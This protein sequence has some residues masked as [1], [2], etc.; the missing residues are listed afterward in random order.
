MREDDR[1]KNRVGKVQ[2][3]ILI[4]LLNLYLLKDIYHW[5]KKVYRKARLQVN[6]KKAKKIKEMM[7]IE[8][9]DY[10]VKKTF[11]NWR[12]VAPSGDHMGSPLQQAIEW[13]KPSIVPSWSPSERKGIQP[14][15]R[16]D[17]SKK[18][19]WGVFRRKFV[20][21][22]KL[23]FNAIC[24]SDYDPAI[25]KEVNG[26]IDELLGEFARW[27]PSERPRFRGDSSWSPSERKGKTS[28]SGGLQLHFVLRP[29]TAEDRNSERLFEI[30]SRICPEWSRPRR[31]FFGIPPEWCSPS[32]G[33]SGL[34]RFIREERFTGKPLER[35]KYL[36]PGIAGRQMAM[37]IEVA[38][39]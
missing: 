11:G 21:L 39:S 14:R 25:V 29:E 15:F 37:F 5:V 23:A 20:K 4:P 28:L 22:M 1:A 38:S 3:K 30:K 10:A 16:G 32:R 8:T 12:L 31:G 18:T 35:W 9:A 36:T 13:L 24:D 34:S 33:A 7:P 26:W 27:T 17:S 6:W 19:R 2:L